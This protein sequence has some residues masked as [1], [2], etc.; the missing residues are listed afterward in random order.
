MEHNI[1]VVLASYNGEKY[2]KEQIDSILSEL[3][4]GD[5]LIISDDG[6]TDKTKE[7]IK[8]ISSDKIILVEG[9]KTGFVNNF[10]NGCSYAK[11][12]YI[13]FS[14]QDD[15]WLKGKRNIMLSYFSEKIKM[16]K[17]DAII[18]DENLQ[19][20][21]ES[22]N[23]LRGA[24]ISFIKNLIANTY[25][26]CCMAITKEWF[27]KL[28]PIPKGIYHDWWIGLLSCKYKCVKVIDDKLLLYRRHGNN[29]SQMKPDSLM[30][31]LKKRLYVIKCLRQ[32]LKKKKGIKN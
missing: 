11:N 32:W 2:I 20:I 18:V 26:G 3:E 12:E 19:T 14:D 24:N 30:K 6:S 4:D 13:F 1:S 7:I 27:N 28:L 21:N 23:K 16:V 22:Y 25:T 17:H 9:P 15:V 31:R 10:I 8:S 5:E 29:V